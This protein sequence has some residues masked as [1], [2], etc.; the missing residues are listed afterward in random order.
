MESEWEVVCTAIENW[1]GSSNLRKT[2][3][4]RFISGFCRHGVIV[5][6]A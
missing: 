4:R 2:E 3:K 1:A 5:L 6:F